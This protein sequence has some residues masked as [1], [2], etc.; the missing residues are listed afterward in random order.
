MTSRHL[1]FNSATIIKPSKRILITCEVK[2]AQRPCI[3]LLGNATLDADWL[4]MSRG[5][6][7][8]A[9]NRRRVP[10][11]LNVDASAIVVIV[12]EIEPDSIAD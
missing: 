7:L 10:F 1:Y 11:P 5:T 2:D 8:V 12:V 4:L 3:W 9:D 6:F